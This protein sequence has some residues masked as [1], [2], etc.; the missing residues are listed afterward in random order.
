[1]TA[2]FGVQ[3]ITIYHRGSIDPVATARGSETIVTGRRNAP[4]FVQAN[5]AFWYAS[6]HVAAFPGGKELC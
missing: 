1:M 5:Q 2:K 3:R 4:V 6:R